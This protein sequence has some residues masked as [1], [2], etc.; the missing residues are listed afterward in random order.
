MTFFT[1]I[2]AF[3]IH[4]PPLGSRGVGDRDQNQDSLVSIF[5]VLKDGRCLKQCL[6]RCNCMIASESCTKLDTRLFKFETGS[7]RDGWDPANSLPSPSD[8]QKI[9]FHL[10]GEFRGGVRA[11]A[12][13]RFGARFDVDHSGPMCVS[14]SQLS[15]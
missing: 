11:W 2:L 9:A 15:D 4:A 13:D 12:S 3:L 5:F 14:L 7:E 1:T 8:K 10:R 6:Q